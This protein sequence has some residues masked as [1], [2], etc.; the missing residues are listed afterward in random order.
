ML[1]LC[2]TKAL[3]VHTL[4]L[5]VPIFCI[6]HY[7]NWIPS[8]SGT[9]RILL[10]RRHCCSGLP[11]SQKCVMA[12]FSCHSE[13]FDVIASEEPDNLLMPPLEWQWLMLSITGNKTRFRRQARKN[14]RKI[15]LLHIC[16][17]NLY[18]LI[19]WMRSPIGSPRNP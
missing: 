1:V 18:Q 14:Q 16:V 3:C 2:S 8:P 15:S 10:K 17:K 12:S 5:S 13:P 4:S 9:E 7:V 6:V 11:G 19:H